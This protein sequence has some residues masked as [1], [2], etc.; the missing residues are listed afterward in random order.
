[1]AGLMKTLGPG[2]RYRARVDFVR[3]ITRDFAIVHSY[4]GFLR[5]G[6][7]ELSIDRRGMQTLVARKRNG[8]WRIE[9]LQVTRLTAD[10]PTPAPPAR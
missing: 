6:E 4:G 10:Q 2:A 3:F 9:S 5:A 1:M 7:T 8:Q